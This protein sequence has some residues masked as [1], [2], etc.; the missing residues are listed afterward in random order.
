[1]NLTY[2]LPPHTS[3]AAGSSCVHPTPVSFLYILQCVPCPEG[4]LVPAAR[5]RTGIHVTDTFSSPTF[6]FFY[7]SRGV[8]WGVK[9]KAGNTWHLSPLWVRQGGEDGGETW[10]S[11]GC[12][13]FWNIWSVS[14]NSRLIG[15]T[16]Q[17]LVC[18]CVFFHSWGNTFTII[19]HCYIYLVIIFW[20]SDYFLSTSFII[21]TLEH[22][23]N[24]MLWRCEFIFWGNR[25]MYPIYIIF[26]KIWPLTVCKS[27][28]QWNWP[29]GARNGNKWEHGVVK[30][31]WC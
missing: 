4:I 26:F 5:R 28:H 29:L 6:F 12:E 20:S 13:G 21:Q 7:L 22:S 10:S 31:R 30:K 25:N 16:G 3:R 24:K 8:E 23:T 11:R 2:F 14:G 17:Q 18:V 1:M 27:Q 15:V 9:G 19:R